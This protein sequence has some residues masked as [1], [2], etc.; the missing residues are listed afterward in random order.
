MCLEEGVEGKLDTLIKQLDA[1]LRH[2]ENFQSY[3]K[4]MRSFSKLDALETNLEKKIGLI[5]EEKLA[6][7]HDRLI[8]I[9]NV[10][11]SDREME[12]KGSNTSERIAQEERKRLK[13][14]LKEAVETKAST[15][16]TYKNSSWMEYIFGICKA[17]GRL[18]KEGSRLISLMRIL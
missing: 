9:F 13:E 4:E 18:G 6:S 14:R 12:R 16:M 1:I 15:E 10:V 5:V 17:D 3:D 7:L 8:E 2:N 11:S